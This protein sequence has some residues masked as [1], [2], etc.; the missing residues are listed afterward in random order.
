VVDRGTQQL[1]RTIY[2]ALSSTDVVWHVD[3]SCMDHDSW[4]FMAWL[5]S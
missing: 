5:K 3:F 2:L 1:P 4:V